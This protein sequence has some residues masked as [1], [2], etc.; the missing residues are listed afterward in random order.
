MSS[1]DFVVVV[2][3]PTEFA[4]ETKAAVLKSNGIEATVI[5]N[6]PSP[7]VIICSM[8]RRSADGEMK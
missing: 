2:T 6:A 4:A 8:T 3:T 5:R 1:D 7:S